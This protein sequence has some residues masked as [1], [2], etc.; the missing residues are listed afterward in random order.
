ME[1]VLQAPAFLWRTEF[2]GTRSSKPA[3]AGATQPLDAHELAA[4]VSFL[5]LNSAPDDGLWAKAV[6]GT[7][8]STAVLAGEVDR[9]MAMPAVKA[10]IAAQVGSWLAVRKTAATVKDR[11]CSRSSATPRKMP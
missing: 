5:F 7:L 9:L 2:G 1:Y 4:A 11:C 8:T 10:N 6:D 3:A